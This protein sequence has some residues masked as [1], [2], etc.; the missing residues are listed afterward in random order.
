MKKIVHFIIIASFLA[1][2]KD[3]FYSEGRVKTYNATEITMQSAILNGSIQIVTEGSKAKLN[4]TSRGFVYGTRSNDLKHTVSDKISGE[5]NFSCHVDS[6]LPNTRY[7]TK[8]FAVVAFADGRE[9]SK[10]P[11][12]YGN[13]IEF[14]TEDGEFIP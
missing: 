5:G 3:D 14:T 12:Y 10:P 2:C 9:G 11:M 6:L 1:G 13:T 8:A 4:I 7:Y